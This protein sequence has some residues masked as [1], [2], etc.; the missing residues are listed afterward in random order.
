MQIGVRRQI[1]CAETSTS[2]TALDPVAANGLRHRLNGLRRRRLRLGRVE[3]TRLGQNSLSVI[4]TSDFAGRLS[5]SK[6]ASTS[7]AFCRNR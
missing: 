1:D 3:Q 5:S 7:N 6:P 4:E 2:E